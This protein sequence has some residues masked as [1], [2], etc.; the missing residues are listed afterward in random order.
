MR[1]TSSSTRS[2]SRGTR[3]ATL[4]VIAAVLAATSQAAATSARPA[5]MRSTA[6][7]LNVVGTTL[8]Q[9]AEAYASDFGVSRGTGTSP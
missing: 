5:S 3:A 6:N 7:A 4:A 2:S 8:E 1:H 9:A